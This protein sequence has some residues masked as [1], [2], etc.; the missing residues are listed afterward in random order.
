M[1]SASV[2][3]TS[4]RR[5]EYVQRARCAV[6]RVQLERQATQHAEFDSCR[7]EVGPARLTSEIIAADDRVLKSGLRAGSFAELVL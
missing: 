3:Q 7:C 1:V 6:C 4:A 2:S 5:T